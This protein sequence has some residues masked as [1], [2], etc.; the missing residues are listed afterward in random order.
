MEFRQRFLE[1]A[2][3]ILAPKAP[4]LLNEFEGS[5]GGPLTKKSSFTW[6]RSATWWIT[7]PSPTPSPSIP[8]RWR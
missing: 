5:A 3:P 4:F 7:A 6:M 1:H 2:Q 8:R